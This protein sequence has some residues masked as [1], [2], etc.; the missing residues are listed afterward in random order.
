VGHEVDITIT[1]LVA[2]VRAPTPSGAAELVVPD[3]DELLRN[4]NGLTHRAALS[5]QRQVTAQLQHHSDLTHRLKLNHPG[6]VI[7]QAKQLA[8][9]LT[10]RLITTMQDHLNN[11][12][13][14]RAAL[15]LRLRNATPQQKIAH[16]KEILAVRR[17]QLLRE[18][19]QQLESAQA[20]F[21]AAAAGLN[22]VSPL[23]TLER[24]YA[25]VSDAATQE[26]IRN[27]GDLNVGTNIRARLAAGEIEASVTK[28][29][30]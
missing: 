20:R 1:D 9:D 26:V 16:L 5:L 14:T 29:K 2:D 22:A 17:R 8:D 28:I 11:G 12:G 21:R 6:A 3:Q 13:D 7:E 4:L 19:R 10:A 15:M 27:A 23:A 30:K 18:T 24:G 25:I